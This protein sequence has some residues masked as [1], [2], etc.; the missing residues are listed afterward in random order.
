[1][2]EEDASFVGGPFDGKVVPYE[3]CS[4]T[5]QDEF[6]LPLYSLVEDAA[7]QD[8]MESLGPEETE[9]QDAE[10]EK[11]D[12]ESEKR[13]LE[14]YIESRRLIQE[15]ME[16]YSPLPKGFALYRRRASKDRPVFD[17]ER[18]LTI[19]EWKTWQARRERNE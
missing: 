18:N 11:D 6:A 13:M 1:M 15:H 12:P 3:M 9:V 14:A 5:E 19:D 17:W 10:T 8:A 4:L 2:T 7:L 16:P